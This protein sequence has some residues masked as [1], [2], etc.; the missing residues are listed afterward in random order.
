MKQ[1]VTK[2]SKCGKVIKV[3]TIDVWEKNTSSQRVI[4]QAS[5]PRCRH[6][7]YADTLEEMMR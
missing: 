5:C 4:Y 2:C 6:T 3:N 1:T 7:I